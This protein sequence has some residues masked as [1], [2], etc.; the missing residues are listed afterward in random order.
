PID[1]QPLIVRIIYS[2]WFYLSI[3]AGLGALLAWALVEPFFV[4]GAAERGEFVLANF[5]LFPGV[6]GGIGLFLG[7]AEGLMCRNVGR[8]FLCGLVGLGIGLGGGLVSGFVG[9]IIFVIMK[10]IAFGM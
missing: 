8:A 1:P 6:A 9:G 10:G 5:L 2:S 7:A 4:E 3:A